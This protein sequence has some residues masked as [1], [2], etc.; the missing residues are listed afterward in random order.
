MPAPAAPALAG[1]LTA[2]ALAA[3]A[4]RRRCVLRG[5]GRRLEVLLWLLHLWWLL[6]PDALRPL[7]K[8]WLLQRQV[9]L[10]MELPEGQLHGLQRVHLLCRR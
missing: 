5:R 6:V 9:L 4:K 8:E 7:Q 3:A 1:S 10:H 2:A